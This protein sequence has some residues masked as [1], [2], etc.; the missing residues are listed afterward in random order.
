MVLNLENEVA[1][2]VV[3]TSTII[4]N[5]PVFVWLEMGFRAGTL[6]TAINLQ[7]P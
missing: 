1:R 5:N 2:R 7:I 6:K 4:F 3:K